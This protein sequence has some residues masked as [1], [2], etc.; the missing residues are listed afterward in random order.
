M[1]TDRPT[2]PASSGAASTWHED[3]LD[4]WTD[5]VAD[6]IVALQA[7]GGSSTLQAQITAASAGDTIIVQPGIY[8]EAVTVDAS[9]RIIFLDGAEIRG[10]DDWSVGEQTWTSVAAGWR[11]TSSVPALTIDSNAVRFSDDTLGPASA[12]Q[13]FVDEQPYRLIGVAGETPDPGEYSLDASDRVILPLN[14]AGHLVEVTARQSWITFTASG[15]TLVRPQARHCAADRG[16]G[17]IVNGTYNGTTYDNQVIV[18]PTF[19]DCFGQAIAW[20]QSSGHRIYDPVI[21][22]CGNTGLLFI[23]CDDTE[24]YRPVISGSNYWGYWDTNFE[25]GGIKVCGE[26]EGPTDVERSLLIYEPQIHDCDGIGI[27]FDVLVDGGAGHAVKVVRPRIWD[28]TGAGVELEASQN[29]DIVDPVIWN[30]GHSTPTA[31]SG[32]GIYGSNARG[33]TITNPLIAWC[34]DGIT[35]LVFDRGDGMP[36]TG[37]TFD[38]FTITNPTILMGRLS[39]SASNNIA[40]GMASSWAGSGRTV[41]TQ[42]GNEATGARIWYPWHEGLNIASPADNQRFKWDDTGVTNTL[43]TIQSAID[44]GLLDADSR[45]L[46]TD[47]MLAICA[48]AGIPGM[49][50][51]D[52][53]IAM[54]AHFEPGTLLN[55]NTPVTVANAASGVLGDQLAVAANQLG[56]G[57]TLRITA[58]GV[59]S[60]SGTPNITFNIRHGTTVIATTGAFATPN[61]VT[62]RG[63]HLTA[64][65]RMRDDLMFGSGTWEIQGSVLLSW[66]G[67]DGV[68]ADLENTSAPAVTVTSASTIDL[69]V[70]WGTTSAS[71]TITCRIETIECLPYVPSSV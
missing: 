60:S 17:G 70:V 40:I 62:N 55:L 43:H 37:W 29:I 39:Q 1:V 69:Q 23:D 61:S 45:L 47:E 50:D 57:T 38:D 71:N 44:A 36:I 24:V 21:E 46:T 28:C 8:R 56:L 27:W 34:A 32:S 12:N 68:V 49:M 26:Q 6:A 9:M 4:P 20:F 35:N 41:T 11:S 22:R 66:S 51:D 33:I 7:G 58:W 10:S 5:A 65:I 30:C 25:A 63:W 54:P 67:G 31:F 64:M 42:T 48:R 13:V 59:F 52:D 14:P 16:V 19:R 18:E 2:A 15:V 53:G 3:E